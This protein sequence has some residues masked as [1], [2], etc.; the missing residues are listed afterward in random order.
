MRA[1]FL[2]ALVATAGIAGVARADAPTAQFRLPDRDTPHVGVAF[3][4]DLVIEG[5]DETPQP[6]VPKLEI[7]G[8][9]VAFV[10]AQPNVSR[11]IQIVNG[12]RSDF[13]KVTW[14]V[15]WQ[16]D[17][18]NPRNKKQP[19]TAPQEDVEGVD[20]IALDKLEEELG[21]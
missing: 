2:I 19:V 3:H 6:E 14:V 18:R 8:A 12:R 21:L 9:Q 4:L 16:I 10:A 15:R 7:P 11:G 17:P 1:A 13:A 5:F 20:T